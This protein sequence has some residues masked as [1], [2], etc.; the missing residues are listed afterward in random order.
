MPKLFTHQNVVQKKMDVKSQV[1]IIHLPQIRWC[2]NSSIHQRVLGELY[3]HS[4]LWWW[5]VSIYKSKIWLI[6][7]VIFI[8]LFISIPE[9][10]TWLYWCVFS[11]FWWSLW[12]LFG[13]FKFVWTERVQAITNSAKSGMKS[14]LP[15]LQ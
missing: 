7:S 10:D 13:L 5:F 2:R 4:I 14:Y 12:I 3:I 6:V 11:R 15:L 9:H 8:W 1:S